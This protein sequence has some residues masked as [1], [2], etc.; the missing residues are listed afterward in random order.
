MGL[1]YLRDPKICADVFKSLMGSLIPDLIRN[2]LWFSR[3]VTFS[4]SNERLSYHRNCGV[5]PVGKCK[6]WY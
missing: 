5:T 3:L 1:V 2:S 4:E 6:I